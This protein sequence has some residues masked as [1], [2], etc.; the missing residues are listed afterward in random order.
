MKKKENKKKERK[1]KTR[2]KRKR[3]NVYFTKITKTE[4]GIKV[5]AKYKGKEREITIPEQA[6]KEENPLTMFYMAEEYIKR[7]HNKKAR[8][9]KYQKYIN[10]HLTQYK[11]KYKKEQRKKQAQLKAGITR[12]LRKAPR[13]LSL[14]QKGIS[15][16]TFQGEILYNP[17]QMNRIMLSKLV[18]NQTLINVL[19]RYAQDWKQIVSIENLQIDGQTEDA[20]LDIILD[21]Q[22][23]RGELTIYEIS[24]LLKEHNIQVG[25]EIDSNKAQELIE[26]GLLQTGQSKR[27]IISEVKLSLYIGK[28]RWNKNGITKKKKKRRRRE[29]KKTRRMGRP[30]RRS[31]RNDT[32]IWQKKKPRRKLCTRKKWTKRKRLHKNTTPTST[33][34]KKHAT[35]PNTNTP[36]RIHHQ[37]NKNS[38]NI[39]RRNIR[40]DNDRTR[41]HNN[42]KQKQ[43]GQ[44]NSNKNNSIKQTRSNRR[45]KN[46][47]RRNRNKRKNIK[48]LEHNKTKKRR[49]NRKTINLNSRTTPYIQP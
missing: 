32:S 40:H 26:A 41:W 24:E 35:Q 19:I 47:T 9:T 48:H 34:N 31:T 20:V 5:K 3:E 21:G 1:K 17:E 49:R 46:K 23:A 2:K 22:N 11:K 16:E 28:N 42:P 37:R 33:P 6:L 38:K 36:R 12:I 8:K 43:N 13:T 4:K 25:Q 7:T 15:R 18:K 30:T 14:I 10:Y 39:R 29:R 27:G 45:R 44:P